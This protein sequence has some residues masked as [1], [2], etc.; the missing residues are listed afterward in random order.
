MQ[1]ITLTTDLGKDDYFVALLKAEIFSTIGNAVQFIDV[2]HSV[3][4]QDIQQAAFFINTTYQKFPKG[5]IHIA[6]VYSYYSSNYEIIAFKKNEH[7]FIGPNNGV[8]SLLFPD[9]EEQDVYSI[10][11]DTKEV[12]K[13]I[14]HGV[15]CIKNN[16][17]PE[18]IGSPVASFNTK[19]A[20]QAVTTN[21]NIRATI[22]HID[23]FENLVLNVSKD[24]FD[25][26]RKGRRFEIFYKQHDPINKISAHYGD[27][28]VGDTL[29]LF[30]S[31]N[32][33]EIAI[34]M[35]KASSLLSLNKNETVQIYFYD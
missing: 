2:S 7:F 20:L 25:K 10:H 12:N 14:A 21:S 28:P 6:C 23:H 16:L 35:G 8:F 18:E 29:C 4:S 33:L 3:D 31:A 24:L 32:L 30:N 17:F 11:L 15:A 13:I 1:L 19:L 5:S 27:V 9:L 34:N 26:Q 22:I